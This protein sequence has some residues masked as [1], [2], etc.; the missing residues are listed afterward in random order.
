[1]FAKTNILKAVNAALAVLETAIEDNGVLIAANTILIGNNETAIGV[2]ADAI[3][4]L[5]S[6]VAGMEFVDRGGVVTADFDKVALGLTGTYQDLD[7][8]SIVGSGR[9]LVLLRISGHSSVAGKY[10]Y[11]KD[12][13]FTG[14]ENT[15]DI[16]TQKDGTYFRVDSWVT[17]DEN[18]KVLIRGTVEASWSWLDITVAGWFV[19]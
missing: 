1:M 2:N 3:T 10:L 11:I 14:E 17:T 19:L 13:G 16:Y 18:G 4:A 8:S 7:L 6:V 15:S 12:K 5:E 9:R